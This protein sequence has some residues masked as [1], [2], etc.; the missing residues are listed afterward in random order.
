MKVSFGDVAVDVQFFQDNIGNWHFEYE[1]PNYRGRGTTMRISSDVEF[2]SEE[3]AKQHAESI[4]KADLEKNQ[5][6][7]KERLL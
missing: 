1:I 3:I 5:T 2:E 7:I 6:E 4:V